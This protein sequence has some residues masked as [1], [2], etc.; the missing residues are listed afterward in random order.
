[1]SDLFA[2]S[3]SEQ[4]KVKYKKYKEKCKKEQHTK[5]IF[6]G[7]ETSLDKGHIQQE[8]FKRNTKRKFSEH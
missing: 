7:S 1:M 8:H 4:I 6:L 2:S 3:I 5:Y